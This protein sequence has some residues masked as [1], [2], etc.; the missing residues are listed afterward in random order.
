MIT[1]HPLAHAEIN[2]ILKTNAYNH[3]DIKSYV[4]YSTMEPCPLGI[5][6]NNDARFNH[7]LLSKQDAAPI[8]QYIISCFEQ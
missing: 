5:F 2:A 4:L 7:L 3:P 1:G 6:L 8:L